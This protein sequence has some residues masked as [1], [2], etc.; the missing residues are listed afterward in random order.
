MQ[1]SSTELDP[2]S[3]EEFEESLARAGLRNTRQ[4]EHIY[5]I[6]STR[7]DHPTADDVYHRAKESMPGISLATVYNCL[8]TLTTCGLLRQV[9]FDRAPSRFCPNKVEHAH[10]YCRQTGKIYDVPLPQPALKALHKVLPEGFQAETFELSFQGTS[11][12]RN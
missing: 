11:N 4:R 10:F 3:R 7:K 5:A 2:H 6:V 9:N 12:A 1:E 8:E